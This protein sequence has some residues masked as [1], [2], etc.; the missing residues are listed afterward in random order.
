MSSLKQLVSLT[1][2]E[3][4]NTKPTAAGLLNLGY[5]RSNIEQALIEHNLER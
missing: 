4:Q 5:Q 3:L 2:P 1:S